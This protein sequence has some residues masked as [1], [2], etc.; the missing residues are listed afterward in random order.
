MSR[1]RQIYIFLF[2]PAI[3]TSICS[4]LYC[5]IVMSLCD[6]FHHLFF[7]LL[8]F[9]NF[10]IH[11][12]LL[13]FTSVIDCKTLEDVFTIFPKTF[14]CAL[15]KFPTFLFLLH[16]VLIF[17]L[18]AGL[19]FRFCSRLR[20]RWNFLNFACLGIAFRFVSFRPPHI[21]YSMISIYAAKRKLN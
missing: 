2:F 3:I 12:Y 13:V 5:D 16:L 15:K 14:T 9:L 8:F 21:K 4:I 1:W 18:H 17:S 10:C 20:I 11:I 6:P 19:F 7:A